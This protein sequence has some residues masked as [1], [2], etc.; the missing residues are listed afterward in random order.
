M[1][2]IKTVQNVCEILGLCVNQITLNSVESGAN[3]IRKNLQDKGV[4]EISMFKHAKP[5]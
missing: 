3:F 2:V 4:F 1:Y 5:L